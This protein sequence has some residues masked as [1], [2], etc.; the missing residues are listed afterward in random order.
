VDRNKETEKKFTEFLD[1]IL[2]GEEVP[3]DPGMD[4]D[5]RAVL[6]F[7]Q[8]ISKL[9][10]NPSASYQASL[11]ARLLQKLEE[12][13]AKT[14]GTRG[15][16]WKNIWRQPVWQGVMAVLIVIIVGSAL[17]RAGVFTPS[18]P[19]AT[20][21]PTTVPSTTVPPMTSAPTTT[22]PTT[23]APTTTAPPPTT[24]AP[25][26]TTTAPPTHIPGV[27]L[28]SVDAGTDKSVYQ[29]GEEVKIELILR[30]ATQGQITIEKLPPIVSLMR[31]DTQKPVYTFSAGNE[32]QTLAPNETINYSLTWNQVDFNG[33][34]VSGSFYVK[35]EDLE[36]Q[37][38][39]VQLHLDQPVQF[40]ILL[41]L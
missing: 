10:P 25:P 20:T 19:L 4:E 28:L 8:K 17:W 34:P 1:R 37:G 29:P 31:T 11:K 36:F 22:A 12:Q 9:R 7:A 18:P 6:D 3:A 38:S 21:P 14:E 13:E 15:R 39:P 35:L 27:T 5:L 30:N 33:D 23:T 24:T 41:D 16:F 32:I 2:A 26:P 40:D